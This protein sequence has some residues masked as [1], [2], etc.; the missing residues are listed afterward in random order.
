MLKKLGSRKF[1]ALVAAVVT[2]CMV[3]FG[4][5][6]DTT[7]RI[8]ALITNVGAV[9]VYLLVEGG[10]DKVREEGENVNETPINPESYK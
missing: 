1:W 4:Y 7:L 8:V 5:S 6:E 2:S 3:L 9:V 10:I